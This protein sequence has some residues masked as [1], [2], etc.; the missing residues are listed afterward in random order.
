MTMQHELTATFDTFTINKSYDPSRWRIERYIENIPH[1]GI[2]VPT[3]LI[4]V[5]TPLGE[6]VDHT[7]YGGQSDDEVIVDVIK[8]LRDDA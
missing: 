8:S 6:I 1:H 5:R 2:D 7:L 4:V 3:N